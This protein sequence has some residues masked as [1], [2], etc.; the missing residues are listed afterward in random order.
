MQDP[1]ARLNAALQDLYRA[2]RLRPG[3]ANILSEL[4]RY[5]NVS[6]LRNHWKYVE[7]LVRIDPLTPVTPLVVSSYRWLNGPPEDAAVPARRSIEMAK[8]AS[9]LQVVA[10]WQIA[11]AGFW[12]EAAETLATTGSAMGDNAYGRFV[13]FLGAA[14]RG[15]E[16]EAL[17]YVTPEMDEAIHNEFACRF[18]AEAY[19][20]LGRNEDGLRWLRRAIGFGLVHYPSLAWDGRLLEGLR[21]EPEFQAMMDKLEPRWRAIMEWEARFA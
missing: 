14:L 15:D 1:I 4:C 3:D 5:S 2:N 17:G 12:E 7:E 16:E 19:A 8:G 10:G 11:E 21:E 20:L 13:R 6:G 9:M 18:M